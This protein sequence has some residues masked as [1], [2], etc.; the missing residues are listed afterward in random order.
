MLREKFSRI[1]N[2]KKY[3]CSTQIYLCPIISLLLRYDQYH[4]L[5]IVYNLVV[6]IR[7]ILSKKWQFNDLNT[8]FKISKI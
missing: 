6:K 7:L 8:V 2:R 4:T 5:V 3:L 1:K